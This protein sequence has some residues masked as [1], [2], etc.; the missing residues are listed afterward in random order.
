MY[1]CMTHWWVAIAK[2]EVGCYFYFI[3]AVGSPAE[4]STD[5]NSR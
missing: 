3:E 5:P 2:L 1:V 4:H